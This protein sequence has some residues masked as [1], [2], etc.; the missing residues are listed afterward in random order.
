MTVRSSC[1]L[2]STFGTLY[3]YL[4]REIYDSSLP[5]EEYTSNVVPIEVGL[6]NLP[7]WK[8]LREFPI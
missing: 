7:S 3:N 6:D 2:D 4:R 8:T 5:D 1:S